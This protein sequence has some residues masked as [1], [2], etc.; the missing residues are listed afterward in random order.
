MVVVDVVFFLFSFSIP[1]AFVW[2]ESMGLITIL[3]FYVYNLATFRAMKCLVHVKLTGLGKLVGQYCSNDPYG[4]SCQ[5]VG[6]VC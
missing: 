2:S 5:F 3:Y 4:F 1:L 6:Y